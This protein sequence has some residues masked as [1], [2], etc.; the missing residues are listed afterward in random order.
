LVFAELMPVVWP[1]LPDVGSAPASRR[2]VDLPDGIKVDLEFANGAHLDS[3]IKV[4]RA[5]R[6][7]TLKMCRENWSSGRSTRKR[8]IIHR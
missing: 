6:L 5:L 2:F 7:Q 3:Y 1:A 8:I 4:N